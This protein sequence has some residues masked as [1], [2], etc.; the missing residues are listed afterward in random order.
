MK[1][2][3]L[4]SGSPRR[5]EL[6]EKLGLK[7]KVVESKFVEHFNPSLKPHELT[8][9]LSVEK[10]KEVS[11]RYKNAIII[12]ADT[13][14]A[15][16]GKIL[17]KPLD[18][19]DAKSMLQFLSNKTHSIITAFT[20]IEGET[21]KIITKSE[22]T[23]IFMRKISDREI[24]S[25]LQTKEPYDKAG[26]YAVQGKAKKFIK[27]IVGDFDNAVG[28]PTHTLVRELKKL[29]AYSDIIKL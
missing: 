24:D 19:R 4:A 18:K 12:A 14:V 21:S 26:A 11:K 2:I 10:A 23:K 8:E 28:L 17:G 22:E 6:L 9:M 7:F 27:K 25:Y 1:R 5:R 16:D 13:I 3:I 15:C 29:G 20:I